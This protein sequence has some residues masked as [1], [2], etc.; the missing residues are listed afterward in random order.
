M[1][2]AQGSVRMF[3][4]SYPIGLEGP[5]F[6]PPCIVDSVDFGCFCFHISTDTSHVV[7]QTVPTDSMVQTS[8]VNSLS[9]VCIAL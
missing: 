1:G 4:S 3:M 5:Y 9:V 2:D 6:S 8:I 7:L